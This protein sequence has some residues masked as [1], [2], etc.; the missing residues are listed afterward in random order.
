MTFPFISFGPMVSLHNT[1]IEIA[2]KYPK[3]V[4]RLLRAESY[5]RKTDS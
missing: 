4:L 2:V 5:L 1:N 3:N